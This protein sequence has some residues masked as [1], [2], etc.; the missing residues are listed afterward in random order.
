MDLVKALRRR[1]K[2]GVERRKVRRTFEK[3][4]SPGVIALIEKDPKKYFDTKPK[5]THFQ[6]VAVLLDDQ[7]ESISE[8]WGA[9][10][11]IIFDHGAWISHMTPCLVVACFGGVFPESDTDANRLK[12]V[13][14]LV[15]SVGKEIR[16]AHGECDGLM[17]N[18]GS[19]RRFSYGVHIPGFLG[20]LKKLLESPPGTAMEFAPEKQNRVQ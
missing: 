16:L 12:L 9:V 4:V 10:G 7:S 20:L 2:D 13:D 15:A 19:S 18:F 1:I 3:Y 6:F 14:A 8:R 5:N 11:D 17:G